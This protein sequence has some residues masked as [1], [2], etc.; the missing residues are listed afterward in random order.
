MVFQ[1]LEK[2]SC[3][4]GEWKINHKENGNTYKLL[5]INLIITQN[6]CKIAVEILPFVFPSTSQLKSLMLLKG[7]KYNEIGSQQLRT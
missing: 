1:Y 2:S 4:E 5:I 7:H 6:M 3:K